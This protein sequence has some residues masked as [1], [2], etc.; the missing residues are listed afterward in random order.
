[1]NAQAGTFAATIAHHSKSF[2]LAAKLL[3]QDVRAQALV[4]YAYCRRADDAVDLAAPAEQPAA[5]RALQAELDEIYA[6]G[7]P[8]DPVT[9]AFAQVARECGI[10]RELPQDLI[11]GMEMDVLGTRYVGWDELLRY[12]HCVAGT[13]GLMMC[14]VMGVRDARAL[15]HADDLGIA[16]QLTNICRDVLEDWERGRLYLPAD[17]L[18]AHGATHLDPGAGSP[19]PREHT[20]ALQAGIATVLDRAAVYYASGDAGLGYLSPRCRVAIRAARLI[21]ASI[22]DTLRERGCD[23]WAGRAVVPRDKKVALA[24]Q[25]A[26]ETL[27]QAPRIALRGRAW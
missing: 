11:A 20:V 23:P 14:H 8:D 27:W 22:G 9:R 24:L 13:V 26:L 18:A 4:L 2:A 5:L 19:L 15:R 1:M 17:V 10:P 12:C 16:M 6:G 7:T 21:Y 3:P 25:A